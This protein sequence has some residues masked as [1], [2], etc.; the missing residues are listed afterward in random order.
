MDKLIVT[1]YPRFVNK[2]GAQDMAISIAKG[3]AKGKNPI[4]M[5][6]NPVIRDDY[7]NQEIDFV[8]MTI[9]NIRK[10]YK[11]DAIFLS[12]HRKTTTYLKLISLFCFGNNLKIVHVA[13]NTFNTLRNFTLFPNKIVAVSKTV[14]D[15]LIDYFKIPPERITV[16]YN[17]IIDT[18]QPN[19]TNTPDSEI[20]KVLFIGRIEPVKRQI[21]FYERTNGKIDSK[22]KIYFAGVGSDY[23]NLKQLTKGSDQYIALGL[24]DIHT[25]LYNYDYVCLFSEKEGLPLS[26]IEGCMF[27]KP[28]L[29]NAIPSSLEVNHKG[30]NGLVGNTWE[31]IINMLNSLPNLTRDHYRQLGTHSRDLFEKEFDYNVMICKY[32]DLLKRIYYNEVS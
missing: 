32:E 7:R 19:R 15:N 26:L 30:Y 24:I 4:I 16:I 21:Q 31:D 8:K 13:H 28:L 18:F 22:I 3:L 14:R 25:E 1:V 17:G 29:T 27:A 10:Y 12:H 11:K 23:E 2:G 9:S 6:D 5:Y 20:I